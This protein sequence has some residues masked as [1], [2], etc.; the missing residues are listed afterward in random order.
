MG[1][2]FG[3]VFGIMDIEEASIRFLRDLLMKEENYCVPI[4]VICGA[5]SG[6]SASLIDNN[7][8]IDIDIDLDMFI[9]IYDYLLIFFLIVF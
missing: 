8:C 3:M 7:V 2:C 6:M 1:L 5:M 9:F 4:G